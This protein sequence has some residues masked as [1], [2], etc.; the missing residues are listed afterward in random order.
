MF[1][2][3]KNLFTK[4]KNQP[5]QNRGYQSPKEF[6][7]TRLYK[8]HDK[9]TIIFKENPKSL[10][11]V[12]AGGRPSRPST[13]TVIS[14]SPSH[15]ND[16]SALNTVLLLGLCA[17]NNHSHHHDSPAANDHSSHSSHSSYDSGSSSYDGG[18]SSYDSG[19]SSD[20]G[21]SCG[22]CD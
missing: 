16:N 10:H 3:L 18:G 2:F 12:K 15:S 7:E 4:D 22:G 6:E 8:R 20:G 21:G 11:T 14:G 9:P 1:K 19:G 5:I 17:S 13:N